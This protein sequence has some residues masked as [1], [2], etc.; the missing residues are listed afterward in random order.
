MALSHDGGDRLFGVSKVTVLVFGSFDVLHHGHIKFLNMASR[1]GD[2]IVGLGTDDYQAQY[3]H[4][5]VLSWAERAEAIIELG[6]N[7]I[8]RPEV[9]VT[10]IL[11]ETDPDY[12]VAGADWIDGPFL[13]LCGVSAGDLSNR[14]IAL[15]YL[16]RSHGM[17][18]SE[19]L[20]RIRA[21]V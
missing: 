13:E 6:H 2:V 4:T 18:S 1:L 16:P 14:G 17:S 7:V 12:L 19:I 3:K 20:R 21:A 10:A 15:V 9:D 8:A 11:D 5:P